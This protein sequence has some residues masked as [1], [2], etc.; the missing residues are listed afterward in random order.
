MR[1]K[2]EEFEERVKGFQ[3]YFVANLTTRESCNIAADE[4]AAIFVASQ[5]LT[6]FWTWPLY[7]LSIQ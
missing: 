6:K 5:M 3:H 7:E 1:E 2:R 4:N